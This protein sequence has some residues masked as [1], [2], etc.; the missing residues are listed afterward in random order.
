MMTAAPT[1]SAPQSDA[2]WKWLQIQ[3]PFLCWSVIIIDAI[4][5]YSLFNGVFGEFDRQ[6]SY[7]QHQGVQTGVQPFVYPALLAQFLLLEVA[8]DFSEEQSPTAGCVVLMAVDSLAVLALFTCAAGDVSFGYYRSLSEYLTVQLTFQTAPFLLGL[9]IFAEA[10]VI[11]CQ[12]L[13]P[14]LTPPAAGGHQQRADAATS[15]FCPAEGPYAIKLADAGDSSAATATDT[16]FATQEPQPPPLGRADDST[17]STIAPLSA[18]PPTTS[19]PFNRRLWLPAPP[20]HRN[21][22]RAEQLRSRARPLPTRVLR[23]VRCG[24]RSIATH[25]VPSPPRPQLRSHR[26]P[27][28]RRTTTSATQTPTVRERTDGAS[29]TVGP[30]ERTDGASQTVGPSERTDGA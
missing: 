24:D 20:L 8:Y 3:N 25:K 2:L 11:A 17:L 6:F 22:R 30:S 29:Q 13:P 10:A 16:S 4:V 15:T 18:P 1:A 27:L 12:L 9:S 26:P 23:Y 14:H 28:P 5:I 21:P 7:H 19:E